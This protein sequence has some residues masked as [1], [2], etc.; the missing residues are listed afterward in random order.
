LG[1]KS[2]KM[3][4]KETQKVE[5]SQ[6]EMK[7]EAE[8]QEEMTQADLQPSKPVSSTDQPLGALPTATNPTGTIPT[9]TS[10]SV[11]PTGQA[12][13]FNTDLHPRPAMRELTYQEFKDYFVYPEK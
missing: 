11:L 6:E 4:K 8:S 13:H 2:Q 5:K 3:S 7:A 10:T 9:A 1:K 12:R